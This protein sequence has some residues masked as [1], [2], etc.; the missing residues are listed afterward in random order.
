MNLTFC[1]HFGSSVIAR[2]QVRKTKEKRKNKTKEK[3]RK[4]KKGKKNKHMRVKQRLSTQL[5]HC[6]HTTQA[7]Q[8]QSWRTEA[9]QPW[10]MCHTWWVPAGYPRYH[11]TPLPSLLGGPW[12]ARP[13][14]HNHQSPPL[15][16]S[17]CPPLKR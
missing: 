5:L 9:S 14:K 15:Y 6:T 13:H 7:R 4:G 16:A 3:R 11:G 8:A 1:S 17:F 12:V 10:M 2:K